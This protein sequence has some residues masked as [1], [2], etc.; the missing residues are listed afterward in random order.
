[1]TI[2]QVVESLLGKVSALTGKRRMATVFDSTSVSEI[3]AELHRCGFQKEGHE[4]LYLGTTGKRMPGEVYIGPTFYQKLKHMVA[5]KMHARSRGPVHVLTRQPVEGRSRD[6]GLRS[7][8]MGKSII[9][10]SLNLIRK[11]L[12]DFIRC[13]RNC[14]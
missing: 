6:G 4:V 3:Q 11:R 7:G 2:G 1:M 13:I 12:Y 10:S 14:K 5:D 8:E 9:I